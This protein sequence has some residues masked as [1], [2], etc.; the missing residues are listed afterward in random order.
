MCRSRPGIERPATRRSPARLTAL[1]ACLGSGCGNDA[2]TPTASGSD[3]SGASTSPSS[4]SSST[5]DG[6]VHERRWLAYAPRGA[7]IHVVD[8]AERRPVPMILDSGYHAWSPQGHGVLLRGGWMPWTDEGPGE[9]VPL[10]GEAGAWSPSGTRL[11]R[12]LGP[13]DEGH[14]AVYAESGENIGSWDRSGDIAVAEFSPTQDVLAVAT[15]PPGEFHDIVLIDARTE[16]SGPPATSGHVAGG[17]AGYWCPPGDAIVG[18]LADPVGVAIVPLE[19][20]G[21]GAPIPVPV[22]GEVDSVWWLGSGGGVFVQVDGEL[23]LFPVDDQG[24]GPHVVVSTAA[25]SAAHTMSDPQDRWILYFELDQPDPDGLP[26]GHL[27]ARSWNGTELGEVHVLTEGVPITYTFGGRGTRP[28]FAWFR[29]ANEATVLYVRFGPT[30]GV[31]PLSRIDFSGEVPALT[32]LASDARWFDVSDDDS[33]IAY[34]TEA[35][36]LFAIDLPDGAPRPIDA[37]AGGILKWSPDAEQL[38]YACA[39]TQDLCID[40]DKVV[41]SVSDLEINTL[42]WRPTP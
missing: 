27:C 33:R 31:G 39:T 16:T 20:G 21:I 11:A 32:V 15:R 30:F 37:D 6:P 24:V 7:N 17:L 26:M 5:G 34:N 40:G 36:E 8:A 10:S 2:S 19:D 22:E 3:T 42:S 4:S 38:A 14:Y 25:P 1:L 35:N 41:S 23:R 9:L 18:T 28:L 13:G 12:R 29:W